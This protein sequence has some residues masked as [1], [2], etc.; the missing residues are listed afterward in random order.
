MHDTLEYLAREPIHRKHH[1]NDLTFGLLY[2]FSREFRAAAVATTRSCTARARCSTRWPATTGRNSP[3]CAPTTPSCGAIPARSCCSWARSSPSGDE[4]SE[5]RALDWHLLDIRAASR[6]ADAGPRPQPS[7]PRAAGAARARLRGRGLR[8]ADRRRQR[9]TRSSPGCARRRRRTPVAVDLELHAGAARRLSRAAAAG[10][11]LARDPQYR[12]RDLR[13]LAARA[14]SAAST[15]RPAMAGG[16]VARR[17]CC[18]RWRRSC[19]N[20]T[21]GMSRPGRDDDGGRH[22]EDR[23]RWRATPWPMCWPA[24]AAAG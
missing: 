4:W 13:R 8:V 20:S 15:P 18:R 19:S 24:G 17:C 11:A 12:R 3:T 22:G 10:R 1:H 23:S 21:A 9:R 5:A 6:R 14:I 16:A 7:L 2:A